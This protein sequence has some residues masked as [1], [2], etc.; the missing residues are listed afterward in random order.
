MRSLASPP[1]S[2]FHYASGATVLLCRIIR[3]ALGGSLS[4]YFAFP[5]QALFDRIGMT[6]AVLEP[7]AEGTFTGSSFMYATA[8]DWAKLGLLFLQ[9]GY[10]QVQGSWEQILPEGWVSYSSAASETAD[11]YGA[12][13]WRGVPNSFVPK[14]GDRSG[15]PKDAFLASGYQG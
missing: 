12:H 11:F 13:F 15:W 10:W 4:E 1:G 3:E 2:I 14:T 6:S 7:D 9:D 8:R 5:R